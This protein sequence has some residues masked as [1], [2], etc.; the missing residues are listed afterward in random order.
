LPNRRLNF[1]NCLSTGKILRRFSQID[2]AFPSPWHPAIVPVFLAFFGH[3][4]GLLDILNSL[5]PVRR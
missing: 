5:V 4:L 2:P 3:F 1:L